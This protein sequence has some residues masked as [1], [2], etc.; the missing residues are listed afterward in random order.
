[1]YF[2]FIFESSFLH[3]PVR[4]KEA[5]YTRN[6][7][8]RRKLPPLPHIPPHPHPTHNLCQ[9]CIRIPRPERFHCKRRTTQTFVPANTLDKFQI[10]FSKYR[11]FSLQNNLG[12]FVL[13]GIIRRAMDKSLGLCPRC[14]IRLVSLSLLFQV[15]GLRGGCH[16]FC[17]E[18][19]GTCP[20]P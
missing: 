1:L 2:L 19:N 12:V 10:C 6:S 17:E 4:R 14:Q 20:S 11:R 3:Y 5:E 8:L 9:K 7:T 13:R 15:V 18:G 16:V